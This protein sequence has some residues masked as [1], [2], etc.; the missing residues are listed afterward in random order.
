MKKERG[1]R[2]TSPEKRL[3]EIMVASWSQNFLVLSERKVRTVLLF[4][5]P[6]EN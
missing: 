3:K 1:I 6:E 5:G 2:D 4:A